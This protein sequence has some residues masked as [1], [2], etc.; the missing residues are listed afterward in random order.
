MN[1]ALLN[2][3]RAEQ[4]FRNPVSRSCWRLRW[5]RLSQRMADRVH[6]TIEELIAEIRK[7]T[8]AGNERAARQQKIMEELQKTVAKIKKINSTKD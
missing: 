1:Q 7:I 8:D 4:F 3:S 5:T 2:R 6:Q